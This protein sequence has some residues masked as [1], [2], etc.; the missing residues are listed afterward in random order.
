MIAGLSSRSLLALVL[1]TAAA[2]G[3]AQPTP[4]V[5]THLGVEDG[6]SQASVL[7]V[8]QDSAGFVWLA[9]ENGLNRYDGYDVRVYSRDR[10]QADGLSNDLIWA[11]AEDG[12]Q[13]LWLATEGGGVAVWDRSTDS[14]RK[15]RHDPADATTLS[16][17]SLR[18]LLIDR[19]G[20]VWVASS[21]AGLNQ[22]DPATGKVQRFRHDTQRADSLADDTL[23][24]LLEDRA[25][26]LWIGT[27]AGLDRYDASRQVFEHFELPDASGEARS[28][29][30]LLQDSRGDI[31]IGTFGA[32]LYRLDTVTRRFTRF[33]NDTRNPE[34]LSGDDVRAVYEDDQKRLWVGTASGLNLF[35]RGSQTFLRYQHDRGNQHSLA[36][37]AVMSIT[38]D[39]N[40]L[41]WIGTR[42]GGAS[43]WNPRSWS[44][45]TIRPSWSKTGAPVTSFADEPNGALWIGTMGDGLWRVPADATDALPVTRFTSNKRTIPG[46]DQVMALRHDSANNL[47]IGTLNGG[48]TRLAPD[49]QMLNFR[50]GADSTRHLGADGIMSLFEDH[51]GRMWIGTFEGGVSIYDPQ[52]ATLSRLKDASGANTWLEKIR[53]A[54]IVEDLNGYVW[55]G[56]DGQGLLLVDPARG[57]VRRYLE[58][59]GSPDSISSNAIYDLTV[60]S[61]G[62][63][64]IGT[65]GGGLDR[66]IGSSLNPAGARF[67]N[68]GAADGLPSTVVYGIEQD[69]AAGLWLSTNGGLVRY[70]PGS[71]EIKTFHTPHGAQGEEFNF[72]AHH[73]TR[74]GRLLF[75]GTEGYNDFDPRLLQLNDHAP[76]I[77]LTNLSILNQDLLT[78]RSAQL[79]PRVELGYRENLLSV[80]FAATDYTDPLKNS[81]MYQL[82]GFDERW[83]AL[84]RR[85]QIDFTNLAPGNYTLHVRAASAESVWNNEGLRL[86]IVVRPAPWATTGAYLAYCI[87]TLLLVIAVVSRHARRQ[88]A[89]QEYA[90]RLETEVADR[91]SELGLRNQQLA[92]A[93]A[94]KS[95]FLARMSHEIRTPMNGIIGM[96]ELLNMTDLNVQQRHY[97]QTIARSGQSLLQIINDILDL[98]KIEAGRL[99][100]EQTSFDLEDIAADC[101]GLLAPLASKKD[102]ELVTAV[103]PQVPHSLVGDPLR[104]RQICMNLL[105]NALKFT[106][107]GEI[108]LRARPVQTT[109]GN[110]VI[111]IEVSDTGIGME[112]DVLERIFEA[113]SQADESTTR[114]FGGTG[115]G[116]S[117]CRHLVD[118]MDGQMGVTSQPGIGTTFWCE[119]PFGTSNLQAEPADNF[120]IAG[121]RIAVATPIR[122]LQEA[123][124]E[125]LSAAGA[126]VIRCQSSFELQELLTL[127]D[128]CDLVVFDSDR[129]NR[130]GADPIDPAPSA[131][132]QWICISRET[133]NSAQIGRLADRAEWLPKPLSFRMLCKTISSMRRRTATF[134][135]SEQGSAAQAAA[136]PLVGTRVLVVEDN[137]VNQLVAERMLQVL[138]CTSTVVGDGQSAVTRLATEYFDIVLMDAQIPIMD[139]MTATRSIRRSQHPNANVPIVGLTAH[140]SDEA[141]ANCLGA[142]MN[143]YLSKPFSLDQLRAVLLRWTADAASPLAAEAG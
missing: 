48:V 7:D 121:L 24:A 21:H 61:S 36:D 59:E 62:T 31:W 58:E 18:N 134:N 125:Q 101:M 73:R 95:N 39:R 9:T 10:R 142:G 82:E 85:R 28:V 78:G 45:G 35:I 71:N 2:V 109:A 93:S 113:F 87:A 46:G 120:G 106:H 43:R 81:Y 141:R 79:P 1:L 128:R 32:G 102:L 140:A 97:S 129:L 80:G 119:I 74:G 91:T 133:G 135:A 16:S 99:A 104:L 33:K 14:F 13:N 25:G 34:S 88:R 5:F 15:F 54:T 139:G 51:S 17:D 130:V 44:L 103:S 114:R 132:T 131:G 117:I 11:I 110:V 92:E 37:D 72:G 12:S 41:L 55:I 94:A 27:G 112:P 126:V 8:L 100:L 90:R 23:Y 47:W 75:G 136:S 98:S 38:Q 138:G 83:V 64:W 19:R 49:G 29:L 42:S 56:T 96:S 123:L 22:L 76:G 111:R 107:E 77:V 65:G 6:L 3:R 69:S 105:G 137:P 4:M 63:L 115:L 89:Q 40:G 84:G 57:F 116:L 50:A 118:L 52:T 66:L 67:K 60:D 127:P 20:M 124:A 122:S 143:D 70:N 30:S 86:P 108:V 68:L 26:V 53:A